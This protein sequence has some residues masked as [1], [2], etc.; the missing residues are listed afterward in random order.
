M[1]LTCANKLCTYL[2]TYLLT[3]GRPSA[4]NPTSHEASGA[5]QRAPTSSLNPSASVF[6]S[7]PV[8][9]LQVPTVT[10]SSE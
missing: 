10:L 3:R 8:N 2:L 4:T 7:V 1:R 5:M 9:D 6:A